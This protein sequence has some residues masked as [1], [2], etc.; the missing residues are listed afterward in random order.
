[1]LKKVVERYRFS[2]PVVLVTCIPVIIMDIGISFNVA[3]EPFGSS[4]LNRVLFIQAFYLPMMILAGYIGVRIWKK[5]QKPL[6]D[7]ALMMLKE[8]EE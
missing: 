5:N 2:I 7:K 1:M 4:V 8:L 6:R 3:N